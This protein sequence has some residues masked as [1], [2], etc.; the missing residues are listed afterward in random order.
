MDNHFVVTDADFEEKVLRSP[1]PVM[2]DFWADWC[3]PCKRLDPI[4]ESIA[5]EYA[6]K[7]LLAKFN[8]D[9]NPMVVG[10][11]GIMGLPTVLLIKNGQVV[12]RITG[13]KPKQR[14]LPKLV[15]HFD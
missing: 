2:V 15:V 10:S 1:V 13:F 8:A 5:E 4:L 3:Q 7:V 6:G 12:E 14:M 11:Y 9:E